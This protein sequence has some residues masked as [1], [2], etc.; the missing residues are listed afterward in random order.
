MNGGIKQAIKADCQPVKNITLSS[1]TKLEYPNNYFD[2]AFTDPPYYDFV[3][4]ADFSDY[5]YVWLKRGLGH[6]FPDVFKTRLTP[7]RQE[8]VAND[9]LLRGNKYNIV[10]KKILI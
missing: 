1:A 4:Y 2:A 6:V 10:S 9:N 3:S 8:L 5:F 7:K